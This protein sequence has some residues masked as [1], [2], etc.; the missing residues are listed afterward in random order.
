MG[1][2]NTDFH[3]VIVKGEGFNRKAHKRACTGCMERSFVLQDG[4]KEVDVH[5]MELCYKSE[6]EAIE[7]GWTMYMNK[8][9]TAFFCPRCSTKRVASI[10]NIV[11][12]LLDNYSEKEKGNCKW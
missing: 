7:D 5:F 12:G 3:M 1:P 4:T 11:F 2:E 9:K 8:N 10:Y 6:T